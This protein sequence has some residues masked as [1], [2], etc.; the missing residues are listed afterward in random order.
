MPHF[1]D[2]LLGMLDEYGIQYEEDIVDKI[3]PMGYQGM[4]KYYTELGVPMSW[5]EIFHT[6]LRR[7]VEL[8]SSSKIQ[9][10]DGVLSVLKQLKDRGER[11][12]V[13]SGSTMEILTPCVKRFGFEN[14]FEGVFAVDD[15]CMSKSDPDV[16]KRLAE[17]LGVNCENCLFFDD[18]YSNLSAAK[19]AGMRVFGVKEYYSKSAEEQIKAISEK[20]IQDF[21]QVL[22]I[23]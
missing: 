16:Y 13:F 21:S 22:G 3:V 1:V 12:F 6:L 14:L 4:S 9:L 17:K 10:K 2:V 20:Y 8:Y 23:E 15:F 19:K 18:N 5:E 7:Q 11:L